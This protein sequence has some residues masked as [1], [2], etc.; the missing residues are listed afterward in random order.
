[1]SVGVI[2]VA[3]GRGA[4][5]GG[6]VPKQ[7]IEIG[8]PSILRRSIDAFDRHPRVDCPGVVLPAEVIARGRAD[9]VG[10]TLK[11]CHVTTGG[12]TRQAS[13]RNGLDAMPSAHDLVLVHDA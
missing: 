2:I 9:V 7:L 6:D 13:V 3:G 4:R 1:M 11:P 10:S 12:E 8:G 5:L